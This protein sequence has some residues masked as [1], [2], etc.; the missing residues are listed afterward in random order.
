MK[1]PPT[2]HPGGDRIKRIRGVIRGVERE[3][4]YR[5]R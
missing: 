2:K 5:I 1:S 3:R 4:D